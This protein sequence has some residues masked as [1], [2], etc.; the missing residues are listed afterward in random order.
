MIFQQSE[1]IS[2]GNSEISICNSPPQRTGAQIRTG[3]FPRGH[4]V[5]PSG[6]FSLTAG[7]LLI[8]SEFKNMS[9]VEPQI[10][11]S[12]TPAQNMA[13]QAFWE[14]GKLVHKET[15]LDVFSPFCLAGDFMLTARM[16]LI[17]GRRDACVSSSPFRKGGL[18]SCVGGGFQTRSRNAFVWSSRTCLPR[19]SNPRWYRT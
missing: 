16:P 19:T 5:L 18:R 3:C 15:L 8:R 14:R 12:P 10:P 11:L 4:K 2:N 7:I 1:V 13:G 9:S 6:G 17:L